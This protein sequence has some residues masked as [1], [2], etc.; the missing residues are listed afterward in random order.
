MKLSPAQ[1]KGLAY[2]AHISNK[3]ANRMRGNAALE[4]VVEA[5]RQARARCSAEIVLK[6]APDQNSEPSDSSGA[7]PPV[8]PHQGTVQT[9]GR[10]RASRSRWWAP[11]QNERSHGNPDPCPPQPP[12]PLPADCLSQ[13]SCVK[14]ARHDGACSP[15]DHPPGEGS[16]QWVP[17][18]GQPVVSK[19]ERAIK[20]MT[21]PI[22]CECGRMATNHVGVTRCECGESYTGP[23]I[24]YLMGDDEPEPRP[25]QA[26]PAV[27]RCPTCGVEGTLDGT[28]GAGDQV[29]TCPTE[30]GAWSEPARN[31][32][33]IPGWR[34]DDRSTWTAFERMRA[35]APTGDDPYRDP[36]TTK[37]A[38]CE[39]PVSV[40]QKVRYE[41]IACGGHTTV[42]TWCGSCGALLLGGQWHAPS[43]PTPVN[44][45]TDYPMADKASYAK[46]WNDAVEQCART[47]LST[48]PI[49]YGFRDT[50]IDTQIRYE[51]NP[52]ATTCAA[53][54]RKLAPVT[55]DP[56]LRSETPLPKPAEKEQERK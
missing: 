25:T 38:P 18:T 24:S 26:T 23:E 31:Q 7:T 54:I 49:A 46:G 22:P 41:H 27:S 32:R 28:T 37:A 56:D 44:P 6:L 3:A 12:Q 8:A 43:H 20:S 21:T 36:C 17:R 5:V 52:Y 14:G 15:W 10:V 50:T 11:L 53:N 55:V 19:A 35:D 34:N 45:C 16:W 13:F 47:A 48:Q 2:F 33:M 9:L 42:G 30:H 4:K 29:Y 40:Q 1:C 51:P 39:H